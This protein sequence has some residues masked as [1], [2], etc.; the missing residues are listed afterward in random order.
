MNRAEVSSKLRKASQYLETQRPT[1]PRRE[2]EMPSLL[3]MSHLL[4]LRRDR[5]L[6]A[7]T[8]QTSVRL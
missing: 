6:L 4:F 5:R 1:S 7:K 8:T 3:R 2:E